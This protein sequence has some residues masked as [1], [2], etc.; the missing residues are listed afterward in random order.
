MPLR[1]EVHRRVVRD[2]HLVRDPEEPEQD[3][4]D[5]AR[6]VLPRGAVVDDRSHGG[7][8]HIEIV[9][10]FVDLL[11]QEASHALDLEIICGGE[12]FARIAIDLAYRIGQLGVP[13]AGDQ[14]PKRRSR[15]DQDGKF[16]RFFIRPIRD[17]HIRGGGGSQ[18]RASSF[19]SDEDSRG[20]GHW[21]NSQRPNFFHSREPWRSTLKK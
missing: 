16:C 6:P 20:S 11:L 1:G 4:R 9:E 3:R 14:I 13:A 2:H 15:L 10:Q 17:L 18:A 7:G 21:P 12:F 8:E 5:D 19:C